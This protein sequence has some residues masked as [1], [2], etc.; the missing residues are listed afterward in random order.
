[1]QLRWSAAALLPLC[2]WSTYAPVASAAEEE[3]ET[4]S[5]F[6][7]FYSESWWKDMHGSVISKVRTTESGQWKRRDKGTRR[8]EARFGDTVC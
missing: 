2:I 5:V 7:P 4:V 8:E 3:P 1:M 6:L